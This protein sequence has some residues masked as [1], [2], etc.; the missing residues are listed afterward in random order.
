MTIKCLH[1][2]KDAIANCGPE[3]VRLEQPCPADIAFHIIGFGMGCTYCKGANPS[4][5]WFWEPPMPQD[6]GSQK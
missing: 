6:H 1:L 5:S 2:P 4:Y 3:E